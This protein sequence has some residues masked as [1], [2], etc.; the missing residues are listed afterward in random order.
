MK[1]QIPA[2][3]LLLGIGCGCAGTSPTTPPESSVASS[4]QVDAATPDAATTP[5]A[6][7]TSGERGGG[8]VFNVNYRMPANIVC[9]HDRATGSH[10][11]KEYCRSDAAAAEERATAQEFLRD[12]MRNSH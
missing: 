12:R 7:A 1:P 2:L 10:M 5:D 6:T 8:I 9:S 4:A 3:A 11:E